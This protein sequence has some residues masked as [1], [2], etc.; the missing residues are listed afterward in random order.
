VP[1]TAQ[2]LT[3]NV[4]RTLE[5]IPP[6][7]WLR[8]L[9]VSFGLAPMKP[10]PQTATVQLWA[11]LPLPPGV[12]AARPQVDVDVLIETESAVWALRV[13]DTVDVEPAKD[14]GGEPIALLA[15]A[16][17]WH[18]R[19]RACYV[20]VIAAEPETVPLAAAV[21][22]RYAR[23]S[24]S[25]QLRLP[26]RSHD[27]ANLAGFGLVTWRQLTAILQDASGASVIE[28]SEQALAS[29]SLRWCYD[30]LSARTLRGTG[31]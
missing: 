28:R 5:L 30:V 3:W 15:S 11:S 9:N 31:T 27:V 8:R 20:G 7:F 4:F 25:L 21:I 12:D 10:A 13:C 17:S 16:A 1:S 14:G 19:R 23:S 24:S 22:G 18:A 26:A 6:A 29:R 2:A